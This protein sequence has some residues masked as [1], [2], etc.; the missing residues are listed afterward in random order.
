MPSSYKASAVGSDLVPDPDHGMEGIETEEQ[1]VA[2]VVRNRTTRTKLM[3]FI[4]LALVIYF[5]IIHATATKSQE[6]NDRI[7]RHSVALT[8]R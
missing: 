2:N 4:K 3:D 7:K 8:S 1:P 5:G 6:L